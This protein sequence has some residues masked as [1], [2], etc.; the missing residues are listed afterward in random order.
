[1][2]C[3]E[4]ASPTLFALAPQVLS[5]SSPGNVGEPGKWELPFDELLADIKKRFALYDVPIMFEDNLREWA[6]SQ[7]MMLISTFIESLSNWTFVKRLDTALFS[8]LN[9]KQ[10]RNKFDIL[11]QCFDTAALEQSDEQISMSGMGL[12]FR[13]GLRDLLTVLRVNPRFLQSQ[14]SIWLHASPRCLFAYRQWDGPMAAIELMKAACL[15]S[16]N[17]ESDPARF[18]KALADYPADGEPLW[19]A[20]ACYLTRRATDADHALMLDLAAHPEKREGLLGWGLK[21]VVRGDI[22][23]D[24]GTEVTLDALADETG[25]PHLPLLDPPPRVY[26][27]VWKR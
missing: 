20:F 15:L 22:V 18:E 1:L 26:E 19:P 7:E 5:V 25:L 16:I 10:D 11:I 14:L 23:L 3:L 8:V 27:I 17:P 12:T 24:D 13:P 21:Y 4:S 6:Y 2:A 9:N